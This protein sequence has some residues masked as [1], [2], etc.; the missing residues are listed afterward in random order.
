MV[1]SIGI[2]PKKENIGEPDICSEEFGLFLEWMVKQVSPEEIDA[3][4]VDYVYPGWKRW[5]DAQMTGVQI[6]FPKCI[7]PLEVIKVYE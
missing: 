1:S 3:A 6:P 2:I 7:R 4:F 5:H